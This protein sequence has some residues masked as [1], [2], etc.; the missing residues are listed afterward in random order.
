MTA[1]ASPQSLN[2]RTD[3]PLIGQ[4]R[5]PGD[6]SISHR[7]LMLGAL[8][9][10]ETVIEGLLEGED[11]L[12]TA[13]A[14]RAMGASAERSEEHTSELHSLMRISYAVFCLKKKNTSMKYV[15]MY[16]LSLARVHR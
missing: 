4:V 15:T 9:I 2:L 6:K 8:A 10:G 14:M 5:V 12:A 7:S 1:A 16:I 11:V 3:Q 13:A